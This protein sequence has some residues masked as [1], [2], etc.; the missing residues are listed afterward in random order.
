MR[1]STTTPARRPEVSQQLLDSAVE[2]VLLKWQAYL[3]TA[4]V[5]ERSRRR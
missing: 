2:S 3:F 1:S 4:E 5:S